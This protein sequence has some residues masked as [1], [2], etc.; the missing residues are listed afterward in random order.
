[1]N[2]FRLL[3]AT[4][5][6]LF[7][8]LPSTACDTAS[9]PAVVTATV[10][11]DGTP[12]PGATVELRLLNDSSATAVTDSAG[13]VR[14]DLA[15][16]EGP[17][18][19]E[20]ARDTAQPRPQRVY[21]PVLI[22]PGES[23]D[24]VLEEGAGYGHYA[25]YA[26]VGRMG[27]WGRAV[28]AL[29]AVEHHHAAAMREQAAA[30]RR[31]EPV[32][33]RGAVDSVR[34]W[35]D[36][37]RDPEVRSALWTALVSAGLRGDSISEAEADRALTEIEADAAIWRWRPS[38]VASAIRYAATV[39]EGVPRQPR[40]ADGQDEAGRRALADRRAAT[41]LDRVIEAQDDTL[42]QPVVL[43]NAMRLADRA[44]RT[45]AAVAYYDRLQADHPES[46]PAELARRD[47]PGTGLDVGRPV[48]DVPLPALDST[49]PPIAPAE[50]AGPATLVDF[51]AAWCTPCV[52]EMP[53]IHDAYERFADRGFDVVSI[54]YD[55]SRDD[56]ARFRE[57]YPM[58]WRHSFVGAEALS[59]GEVAAA[60]GVNGLPSAFLVGPDGTIIALEGELRGE[61]LMQT[62][63][64]VL[65]D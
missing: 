17:G 56:V 23:A 53:V 62:L 9:G 51:W 5:I 46:W 50:L 11:D 13:R 1:M 22:A 43:L 7:A 48:P 39:A 61:A 8:T 41:Y 34:A 30:G 27:R 32:D 10:L 57:R 4:G 15:G 24:M 20:V 25:R 65:G 21:A 42:V 63:E 40:R 3:S 49:A 29:D 2:R 54:S 19:V 59:D 36:G 26:G 18:M 38:T 44:G 47:E 45:E 35:L 58:P 37:E 60:W 52:A 14:L 12:V 33:F 31:G 64:R 28:Q 16:A 6:V 55:A